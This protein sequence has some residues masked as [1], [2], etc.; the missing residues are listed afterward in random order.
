MDGKDDWGWKRGYSHSLH[1]GIVEWYH[2][3]DRGWRCLYFQLRSFLSSTGS[4]GGAIALCSGIHGGPIPLYTYS[5][6][7]TAV[8]AD[9]FSFVTHHVAILAGQTSLG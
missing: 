8:I 5:M 1:P 2:P 3:L 6:E 4:V 9:G 7:S